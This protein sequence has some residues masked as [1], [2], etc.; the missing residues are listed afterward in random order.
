MKHTSSFV[1]RAECIWLRRRWLNFNQGVDLISF[2]SHGCFP[3]ELEMMHLA[4]SFFL[5][6]MYNK[7]T[8]L[9]IIAVFFLLLIYFLQIIEE[10]FPIEYNIMLIGYIF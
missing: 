3:I 1:M 10:I 9:P 4:K 8:L 2:L 6:C 7:Q 5:I